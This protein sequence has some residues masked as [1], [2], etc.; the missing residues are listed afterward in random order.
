[1]KLI[2]AILIASAL[3]VGIG[4]CGVS[5]YSD[6]NVRIT[7]KDKE[8]VNTQSGHEYRVYTDQGTFVMK[9]TLVKGRFD[10]ADDYA[11]L[12]EGQAYDC[13]AFGFRVPLFSSFKNL[14][15]CVAVSR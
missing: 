14:H 7:I 11:A 4:A 2:I 6:E 8:S 13:K 5:Y 9:D 3:V 15:E 12:D 1:M 10:T